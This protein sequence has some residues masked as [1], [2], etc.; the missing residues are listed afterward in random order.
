MKNMTAKIA[1]HSK[2]IAMDIS[3]QI[4]KNPENSSKLMPKFSELDRTLE[5]IE[6]DAYVGIKTSDSLRHLARGMRKIIRGI[7]LEAERKRRLE[8]EQKGKIIS[9]EQYRKG[10]QAGQQRKAA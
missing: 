3:N 4:S 1:R 9:M 2:T 8:Q 6:D 7:A 5:I 10:Q